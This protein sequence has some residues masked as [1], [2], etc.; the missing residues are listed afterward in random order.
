M[1][2]PTIQQLRYL[3]NLRDCGSFHA[4]AAACYVS[5]ST[6]STGI[7]KLETQLGTLLVDRSNRVLVFT[8][9]GEE[10]VGIARRILGLSEEIVRVSRR[11]D[12]PLSGTLRLGAIPTIMPFVAGPLIEGLREE[13]ADCDLE[14][15]EDQSELL[16]EKLL[17][18]RVD[19]IVLA[20]PFKRVERENLNSLDL[21][22]DRFHL[23]ALPDML[24]RVAACG[25][26]DVPNEELLLMAD[27]HCLRGHALHACSD[28]RSH[29]YNTFEVNSLDTLVQLVQRGLGYTMIPEIALRAGLLEGTGV[30]HRPVDAARTIS[31]VWRKSSSRDEEFRLLGELLRKSVVPA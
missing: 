25:Q 19:V 4:A 6:L 2:L 11:H 12:A 13:F 24:G 7:K 8:E 15:V 30:V 22:E 26:D 18:G 14:L 31:L 27:G 5:Q 28:R 16:I 9:V 23:A 1:D 10:V 3:V 17:A 21:F 29:R 20:L